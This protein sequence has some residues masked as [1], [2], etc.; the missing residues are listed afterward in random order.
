MAR[1]RHVYDGGRGPWVVGFGITPSFGM[2]LRVSFMRASMRFL[3]SIYA[4][5]SSVDGSPMA[6]LSSGWPP[7]RL[8]LAHCRTWYDY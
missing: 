5:G 6:V 8:R 3:E 1:R 4:V 2:H 7:T